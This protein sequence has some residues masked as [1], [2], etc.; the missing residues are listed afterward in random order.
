[1]AGKYRASISILHVIPDTSSH[2]KRLMADIMGKEVFDKMQEDNKESAQK[3]LIGKRKEAPIIIKALAKMGEDAKSASIAT[4]FPA[5]IDEIIIAEGKIVEGILDHA[6]SKNCDVI[7]V[8]LHVKKNPVSTT[9]GSVTNGV[10][11]HS[12]IP[13]FS[14]PL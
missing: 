13:V 10:L 14:V 8:G 4:E 5:I 11:Q 1:M 3:V 2:A 9:T 12:K 7:I 6:A